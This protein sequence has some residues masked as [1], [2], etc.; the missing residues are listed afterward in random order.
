MKLLKNA[1]VKNAVYIGT[2]CSIAY[3]MVYVARNILSAVTPKL[4]ESGTVTNEYIG[5]VSSTFFMFYAVGQLVN[6][7]LGDKIKGKYMVSLGFLLAGISNLCFMFFMKSLAAA[8]LV[9][10]L[11]GFFLS[12][13]Y[14]P[15]VKTISENT[16]LLHAERCNLALSFAALFGTPAAGL[17]AGLFMWRTSFWLVCVLLWL[18]AVLYFVVNKGLERTGAIKY[19]QYER[20]VKQKQKGGVQLLL[21][22]GIIPFTII[23]ALTGIVRTSVVF[24]L[25]TYISQHLGFS[26]D[27][28]AFIFTVVTA[29]ISVSTFFA[30]FV[31]ERL[32]RNMKRTIFLSFLLAAVSFA[33]LF[34][35][36]IPFLNVLLITIAIM[37]SNGA[38]TMIWVVYCPGLRDTGMVSTATG[39]LD[40]ISYMAGAVS[41]VIFANAVSAI[42][43]GNLILVWLGL[44]AAGVVT[45]LTTSK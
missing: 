42:G 26:A 35:I 16:N 23:S 28:A 9:Y 14:A 3:L 30:M 2:L 22:R 11:F 19:N 24:W 6:G 39:Y 43:W 37:A 21:Q 27:I 36:K 40:F 4:V 45:S 20:K 33:A 15:M 5:V 25:P 18:M 44:M 29:A 31:Y 38:S 10:G 41:N 1:N 34:F 7:I 8:S 13:I 17:I 12:M 32:H